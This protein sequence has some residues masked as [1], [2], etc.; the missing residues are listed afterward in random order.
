LK[1]EADLGFKYNTWVGMVSITKTDIWQGLERW[2]ERL[3]MLPKDE[4]LEMESEA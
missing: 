1:D 3:P 2:S 4:G